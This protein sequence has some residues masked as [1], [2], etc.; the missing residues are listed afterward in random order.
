MNNRINQISPWINN[1]EFK[2]LNKVV[3]KTYLTENKETFKFESNLKKSIK[4]KFITTYSNWTCGLYACMKILD[5]K[6]DDEVIVPN[7]TFIATINSVIMANLKPVLC[8]INEESMCLDIESFKSSITKKTKAVIPVHLYGNC[9]DMDELKK[10]CKKKKIYIIEDAAQAIGSK[11][12]NNYLGTIGDLGGISFYGN[13]IITTGEGGAVISKSKKNHEKLYKFKNHGRMGKGVFKHKS[14]GFNFMFTEMQA[15]IGNEQLKK[16]NEIIKKKKLIYDYY[17]KNLTPIKNIVF[18][19]PSE[20]CDPVYWFS[21]IFTKD[22]TKLIKYLNAKNIQ[23]REA[24]Y[25]LNLQPCFKKTNIVMN[26]NKKFPL[27]KKIYNTCISLPSSY[28]LTIKEQDLV[29][30]NI[31]QFYDKKYRN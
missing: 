16:L 3:K 5:L 19:R 18:K 27:S 14:I 25:P 20:N 30:K 11:Y 10:I 23:T 7:L 28:S 21:N 9:C 8:E 22:K 26:I 6:P 12:K 31:K 17:K 1:K 29:I 2:N 15:A 24:F 13:K 4:A